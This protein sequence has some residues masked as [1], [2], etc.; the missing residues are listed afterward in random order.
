MEEKLERKNT[1][2]RNKEIEQYLKEEKKA[3]EKYLK[4]PKLL[5][6]GS[7]DCGKS[8]LLKQMKILHGNGFN[9]FE[10]KAA[11]DNIRTNLINALTQM[12]KCTPLQSEDKNNFLSFSEDWP[13]PDNAIPKEMVDTVK[14]LWEIPEVK[15]SCK[16]LKLPETTPFFFNAVERLSEAQYSPTDEDILNL[17][18]VTQCVSETIFNINGSNFHFF[19][20]SG[21]RH[22]RKA[23][24]S[25]FEHVTTV[26]FV[27]SIS[28]YDQNLVEDPTVN[29]MVD[30]L[31]L[32]EQ[33][34]NHKLMAKPQFVLFFNKKDL[35]EVKI[36]QVGIREFFPEYDGNRC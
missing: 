35:Y 5:I 13:T 16:D 2:A 30:S 22:H 24:F 26:L 11:R 8:T 6:L 10:K 17:R 23:W 28:S 31:V 29:R 18:T 34:A 25:Y 15:A 21:L 20:V 7:S 3:Y 27:A 12:L 1:Q 33:I 32:F 19:D 9:E 14:R 4:E 36:K